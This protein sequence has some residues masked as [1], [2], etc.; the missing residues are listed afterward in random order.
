MLVG[1]HAEQDWD[2][3][4]SRIVRGILLGSGRGCW[5]WKDWKGMGSLL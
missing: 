3:K 2:W 5:L 1:G 4:I